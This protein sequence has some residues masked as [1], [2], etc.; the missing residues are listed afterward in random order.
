MKKIILI[1]IILIVVVVGFLVLKPEE[2]DDVVRE[3]YRDWID[4]DGNP[5][6][7]RHYDSDM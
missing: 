2:P 7:D 4:Y 3:F 1:I 6:A 5:T